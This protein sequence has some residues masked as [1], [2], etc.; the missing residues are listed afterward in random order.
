MK[1]KEDDIYDHIRKET[2]K[3]K[4]KI[5]DALE[6]FGGFIAI[7]AIGLVISF[8]IYLLVMG[9]ARL[10]YSEEECPR[11]DLHCKISAP[12]YFAFTIMALG[13]FGALLTW[14]TPWI[15]KQYIMHKY[16]KQIAEHQEKKAE[17]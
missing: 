16:K 12:K 8:L 14:I 9:V 15:A 4:E 1:I 5:Y 17:L 3:L 7:V 13:W 11:N 10:F 6:C 2:Y